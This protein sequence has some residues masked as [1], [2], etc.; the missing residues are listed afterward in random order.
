MG[1]TIRDA[2]GSDVS[3]PGLLNRDDGQEDPCGSLAKRLYGLTDTLR[4]EARASEQDTKDQ[5]RGWSQGRTEGYA[6]GIRRAVKA[7][8]QELAR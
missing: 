7:L 4:G 8:E 1:S 6:D 2:A 5:P 3:D